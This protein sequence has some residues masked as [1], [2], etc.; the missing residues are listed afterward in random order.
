MSV[1]LLIE[2]KV[3]KEK[4]KYFPISGQSTYKD[5][6]LPI[7]QHLNLVFIPLFLTGIPIS[8]DNLK[9]V[10]EEY[11]LLMTHLEQTREVNI[12]HEVIYEKCKII[13][14][15]LNSFDPDNEELFIG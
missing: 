2:N 12:M 13:I 7:A 5:E 3:D 11:V 6:W 9:P 14:D 1:A 4:N 10:I 8:K 15:F